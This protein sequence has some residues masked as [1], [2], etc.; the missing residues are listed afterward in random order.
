MEDLSAALQELLRSPGTAQKL[1]QLLGGAGSAE[2]PAPA[3]PSA[4]PSAPPPGPSGPLPELSS[5]LP[6]L[7]SLGGG[8]LPSEKSE[9]AAMLQKLLP[10]LGSMNRETEDTRLLRALRPYLHGEREQRLDQAIQMMRIA[11]LLPLLGAG[12]RHP[13]GS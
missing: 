11:Q 4:A 5:L 3:P 2:A 13:V 8:N 7:G 9:E 6:L 1:E 12:G 10:L